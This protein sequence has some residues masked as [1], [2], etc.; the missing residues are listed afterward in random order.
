MILCVC[1]RLTETEVREAARGGARTPEDAYASLGC[2]PQ[3]CCCLDYAQEII[4]EEL[5]KRPKLRVV[6]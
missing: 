1:N 2:E 4:D 3:C 5:P 6:A